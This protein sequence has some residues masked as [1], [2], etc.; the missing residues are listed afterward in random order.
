MTHHR[1]VCPPDCPDACALRVTLGNGRV[2]RVAGHPDHP[3]TQGAICHKVQRFPERTHAPERL[4]YP[5]RRVRP[6]ELA[7]QRATPDDFE[8][9]SWEEAL[10]QIALG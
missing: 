9:I 6:K 1:S 4:L 2:T 7:V 8:R 10:A 3:V 5:M